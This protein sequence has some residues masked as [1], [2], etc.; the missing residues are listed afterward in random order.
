MATTADMMS[1]SIRVDRQE[2]NN[3]ISNCEL[4]ISVLRS[5]GSMI[6]VMAQ[7]QGAA[8][9]HWWGLFPELLV[10]Q[11]TAW[12]RGRS[13]SRIGRR[14]HRSWKGEAR[15]GQFRSIADAQEAGCGG[16]FMGR[17][18]RVLHSVIC[19][20][21]LRLV[22]W[23]SLHPQ[24]TKTLSIVYSSVYLSHS[25][26]MYKATTWHSSQN[27]GSGCCLC[28]L[29]QDVSSLSASVSSSKNKERL[30][31][32]SQDQSNELIHVKVLEQDLAHSKW[33]I[34]ISY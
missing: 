33:G 16:L 29:G 30:L 2:L 17:D 14:Q 6:K 26:D 7:W 15:R 8:H 11:S 3:K 18:F 23:V 34:N 12:L 9:K 31:L 4:A 13:G 1:E 19:V 32:I 25:H 21:S 22:P 27:A 10:E 24:S 5:R 20:T 28:D